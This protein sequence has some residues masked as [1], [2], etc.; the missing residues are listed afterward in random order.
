VARPPI[1]K[2]T[3]YGTRRPSGLRRPHWIG[4]QSDH[5]VS[6]LS[7]SHHGKGNSLAR[8]LEEA[9]N[10]ALGGVYWLCVDSQNKVPSE[11]VGSP[12]RAIA[13]AGNYADPL[14]CAN[15]LTVLLGHL[16]RRRT[17]DSGTGCSGP[18]RGGLVV[19][20]YRIWHVTRLAD[21]SGRR[22]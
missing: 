16:A 18:E 4:I 8:Q 2:P 14:V 17:Q 15:F 9:L 21:R 20:R 11:N 5:N 7:P 12:G 1:A 19:A 10:E 3:D 13:G 22:P 6:S